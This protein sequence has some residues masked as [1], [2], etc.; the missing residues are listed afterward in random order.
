MPNEPQK[1]NVLINSKYYK[2][3]DK[4]K[5][6]IAKNG[7]TTN[8]IADLQLLR[9]MVVA[10]NQP[11]L[12]KAIRLTF[13]HIEA[14]ESFHI[15]IPDDEPIEGFEDVE[16]IETEINDVESLD[17]LLSNMG[18]ISNKMNVSDIRDFVNQLIELVD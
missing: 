6:D 9:E 12:A 17:Y 8:I 10:E 16:K 14:N 4:I 13:Q 11:L 15:A 18:D 1:N 5:A 2:L 3:I 7:V